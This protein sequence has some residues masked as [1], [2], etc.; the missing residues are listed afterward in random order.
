MVAFDKGQREVDTGRNTR[1]GPVLAAFAV[2][3]VVVD[4]EVREVPLQSI[5][6]S[7]VGG[8]LPATQQPGGGEQEGPRANAAGST[9]GLVSFPQPVDQL[10][11]GTCRMD[12]ATARHHQ[13]IDRQCRGSPQIVVHMDFQCT[14]GAR[15]SVLL[16]HGDQAIRRN[17]HLFICRGKCLPRPG[18]VNGLEA[19]E[20]KKCHPFWRT[21]ARFWHCPC[22]TWPYRQR[23]KE[24]VHES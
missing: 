22:G 2:D 8:D 7:P 24:G 10:K 1:R 15:Y 17:A 23:I 5:G 13:R 20:Q 16:C 12:T 21:F 9:C 3:L 11:I 19:V 4:P 14:I 6:G 18:E